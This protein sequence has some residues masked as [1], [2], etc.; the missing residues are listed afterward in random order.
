MYKHYVKNDKFYWEDEFVRVVYSNPST[1]YFNDNLPSVDVESIMHFYYTFEI[2]KKV[3]SGYNEEDGTRRY[4]WQKVAGKSVYEFPDIIELQFMISSLLK[5]TDIENFQKD[6]L[7]SGATLYSKRYTS[8]GFGY[9][10]FYDI[11]KII[12]KD[13]GEEKTW[14][15]LY[16]GCTYDGMI[17]FNSVGV[18]IPALNEEDLLE[19]KLLADE[20]IVYAMDKSNDVIRNRNFDFLRSLKVVGKHLYELNKDID[21]KKHPVESEIDSIYAIGDRIDVS[22]ISSERDYRGTITDIEDGF[23]EIDNKR[24][25]FN[26]MT[27]IMD[28]VSDEKLHFGIDEIV[29]DFIRI[30]NN[31]ELSDFNLL[32]E[33]ALYKKYAS[34][35]INRTWMYRNEHA[36]RSVDYNSDLM[37][38]DVD[39]TV[40]TVIHEIKIK[41]QQ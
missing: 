10:D 41:S 8:R 12:E 15:S 36:F 26:D 34:A 1:Q 31:E 25:D 9:D 11:E 35:V 22:T 14:Y 38:H 2:Y 17:G 16:I 30:A 23:I 4:K 13:E 18:K 5:D 7:S 28:S 21:I 40:K 29:D 24:I 19:L 6:N 33:E 27:Y 37:H 3:V 20:F 39:E 32:S